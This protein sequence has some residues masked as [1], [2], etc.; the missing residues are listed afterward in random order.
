MLEKG[1]WSSLLTH[2]QVERQKVRRKVHMEKIISEPLSSVGLQRLTQLTTDQYL[3]LPVSLNTSVNNLLYTLWCVC[4]G[5]V[6]FPIEM[7]VA[8]VVVHVSE[9]F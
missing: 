9:H 3:H 7:G 1:C 5:N 6:S 4:G 2:L 8:V